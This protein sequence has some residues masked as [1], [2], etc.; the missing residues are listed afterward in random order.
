MPVSYEKWLRPSL[1]LGGL[2]LLVHLLFNTGYGMSRDEL[3]FIV[4]GQR[5]AWGYVDQPPVVPMLA[6]WSYA[7]SGDWLT[8]FRLIP[9][10]ALSATV[11][12]TAEFVRVAGG[13]RFAQ[14]L[15]G[16]CTAVALLYLGMGLIFTTDTFQPL[17]WLACAWIL[18]RLEQTRDERW[19]LAFGA[20]VGFSLLSKYLMAFYVVALAIGLL[21]TPLRASLL[22]PWVYA[23]AALAAVIVLPNILWQ[24]AHDWPFIELGKAGVNGK[25]IALSPWSYFTQQLLLMGPLSAPVWLAGLWS[26]LRKPGFAVFRALPIAYGLLF[27]FFVVCHGKASYITAIYPALLAMGA[28]AIESWVSHAYAR[29]GALAAIAL[30]G[31]VYA[32]FALPVMS[33][34]AFIRYS[35]ALGMSPSST[36]GENQDQGKL[37]QNFADMHGWPDM[38]AKVAKVYWS[39]PP[40]DRAKAVFFGS[41]YGEAAAIDVYGHRLGLPPAVSGHNNYFLWGP[42]GHDGSVVIIIGGTRAQ[43]ASLFGSVTVAGRTDSPY[44]MPYETDQPIYVLRDM[45]PPLQTYWTQTK[46]YQ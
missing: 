5:L 12:M 46:R 24:Q 10:L 11:A 6:A 3:Y 42:R 18:V 21:A 22:K 30:A 17:T 2:V 9:A 38:A 25:N 14:W 31:A 19:W 27:A 43:Y 35:S 37:P 40:Q 15:A 16:L 20:V 33:E 45:K 1:V 34:D 23:G 26:G 36:A 39:L 32:P 8:G 29:G 4:C 41:N 28:V 13:G 7:L 44:A